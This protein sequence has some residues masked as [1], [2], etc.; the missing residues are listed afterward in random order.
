MKKRTVWI[1]VIALILVVAAV[2]VWLIIRDKDSGNESNTTPEGGTTAETVNPA[3]LMEMPALEGDTGLSEERQELVDTE[4]IKYIEIVSTGSP[5]LNEN[6]SYVA[7][8]N[9]ELYHE[10]V[11][12][13]DY[14]TYEANVAV[15]I[16]A[17][18]DK[19]YSDT[20]I[21]Q[22][23]RMYFHYWWAYANY[24]TDELIDKLG[25]CFPAGGTSS[26]AL[27]KKANEVFGHVR[28]DGFP[29]VFK[30]ETVEAIV[31]LCAEVDPYFVNVLSDSQ[32]ELVL[33]TELQ[34]TDGGEY[35]RNLEKWL[36]KIVYELSEAGFSER[37][38]YEAQILY[39]GTVADAEYFSDEIS[40]FEECAILIDTDFDGFI[41]RCKDVLHADPSQN[42]YLLSFLKGEFVID[43]EN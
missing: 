43:K 15:L 36:S 17:F 34:F 22:I 8:E 2:T 42:N 5:T 35:E 23:Q 30:D 29:F 16:N 32:K 9:G 18:A 40:R 39:A 1:I 24:S 7:L 6:G 37:Q 10:A 19:G 20:A 12:S 41:E 21:T 4:I 38:I 26:E 14:S 27:T 33:Y 3:E 28:D 13:P 31:P 11:D 25:Q